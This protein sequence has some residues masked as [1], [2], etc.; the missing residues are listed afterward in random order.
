MQVA[1]RIDW[2]NFFTKE[3]KPHCS[4]WLA[5]RTAGCRGEGPA[6]EAHGQAASLRGRPVEKRESWTRMD[7][8][9]SQQRWWRRSADISL[10][11]LS[12]SVFFMDFY[13]LQYFSTVVIL[14]V[15]PSLIQRL[16]QWYCV[17]VLVISIPI[18][19]PKCGPDSSI[20]WQVNQEPRWDSFANIIVR[21]TVLYSVHSVQYIYELLNI[22]SVVLDQGPKKAALRTGTAQLDWSSEVRCWL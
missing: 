7:Q 6:G 18:S 5:Q 9:R 10:K 14:Q 19:L 21:Y 2:R 15:Y 17:V 13:F 3:G 8:L 16:L 12:S 1:C 11:L 22:W 20:L 4:P